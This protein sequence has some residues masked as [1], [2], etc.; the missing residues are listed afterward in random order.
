MLFP[1][2]FEKSVRG[3]KENTM[4][5][6]VEKKKVSES[7]IMWA[8]LRKKKAQV[9]PVRNG[10]EEK[11]S[12]QIRLKSIPRPPK[13]VNVVDNY[14][15]DMDINYNKYQLTGIVS[16]VIGACI[17]YPDL[18]RKQVDDTKL[19]SV[20]NQ[21]RFTPLIEAVDFKNIR[22]QEKDLQVA[23][24]TACALSPLSQYGLRL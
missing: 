17:L 22:L 21:G 2:S 5:I 13:L 16:A 8:A 4:I 11:N 10:G 20:Y 12:L 9:P 24:F 14:T 19:E 7:P 1:A 15:Q 3:A 23:V 18:L 6:L